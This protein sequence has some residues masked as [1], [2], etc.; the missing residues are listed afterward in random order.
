M[1]KTD[2]TTAQYNAARRL[3]DAARAFEEALRSARQVGMGADLQQ[4]L[5]MLNGVGG[6]STKLS[7]L[8]TDC[9]TLMSHYEMNQW[10]E[11]LKNKE[12]P[13]GAPKLEDM[14]DV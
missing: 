14:F 1:A 7:R 3:S 6:I 2:F 12:R 10:T 4:Y 9:N 11:K 13:E 5:V 8:R